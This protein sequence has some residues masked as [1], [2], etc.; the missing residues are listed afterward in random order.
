VGHEDLAEA[1]ITASLE[2]PGVV[3]VHGSG[4]YPDGRPYYAMRFIR[5]ESFGEAI[6]RLHAARNDGPPAGERARALQSLLR[7]FLDV[8]NTV[9]YAHS[10]GVTH[11]DL[12][13]A[14][15]MLGEYGETL[16]VDWGL[17]RCQARPTPGPGDGECPPRAVSA[18]GVMATRP[19]TVSGTPAYM[20]PEQARGEV[21]RIGPAADIYSLGA[22]LYCLLTG[23]APFGGDNPLVTLKDVQRGAFPPPRAVNGAVPRSLEAVCLKAMS[24]QPEGRYGSAQA[25]GDDLERWLAGEP[26]LAAREPWTD[27]ARRWLGRH[28]TLVTATAAGVIIAALSLGGTVLVLAAA[29]RR[30]RALRSEAV[31]A[32]VEAEQAQGRAV[33]EAS[34]AREEAGKAT[35]LANFLVQLFQSSDPLGLEGQ[36]FRGPAEAVD[37]PTAVQILRRGADRIK[38]L[39]EAG[40]GLT[41][42]ALMDAIG[43]S[44]RSLGDIERARALLEDALRVRRSSPRAQPSEVAESLFHLGILDHDA[45]E[46][47]SAEARYREAIR[48]NQ[49]ADGV[50]EL[51]P[52]RVKFR[53]AWLLAETKRTDEAERLFREVLEA[54]LARLGPDHPEVQAA[55]LALLVVLLDGGDR[56]ALLAQAPELLGRDSVM[57]NTV[58]AYLWAMAHRRARNYPAAKRQYEDVLSTA[59]RYLPARHPILG[60]LLGDMAGLYR[61]VGD[62]RRGEELIREALEIG[63][64]TIPL[65][66]AMVEGLTALADELVRQAR[67]GEAEELYLEAIYIG[68]RRNRI[69]PS[70]VRW[71]QALERLLRMERDLGRA[72]KAD[73]YQ[74]VLGRGGPAS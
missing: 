38:G 54:R 59:R 48:L 35:T 34:R 73:E 5:G 29:N 66:P 37:D 3:P 61:E 30:E 18:G 58:V 23:K 46:V 7:R 42:A 24:L 27:R 69:N 62:L 26:V 4:R 68:K 74:K 13:P 11:R 71:E 67:T 44:L 10:R 65:H 32:R 2:H 36:G 53:L 8:C 50:D 12:K 51:A 17:A 16:V 6:A 25:L 21:D 20:S 40:D 52:P 43:N 49:R 64:K 72:G 45:Q 28:R 39:T 55:R 63:R 14:N 70:D 15:I 9:A 56:M 33:A 41:A 57:L 1:E 60:L 31:G 47:V 22:T 19:G